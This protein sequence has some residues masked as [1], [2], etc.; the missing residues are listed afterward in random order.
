MRFRDC[1]TAHANLISYYYGIIF[2]LS[3]TFKKHKALF[4]PGNERVCTK[5][6]SFFLPLH[7]PK[8]I[9]FLF[10]SSLIWFKT[11]R[12]GFLFLYEKSIEYSLIYSGHIILFCFISH[13]QVELWT[14][15][16]Y[17]LYNAQRISYAPE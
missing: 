10:A 9:N 16:G 13:T 3:T 11:S 12:Y 14:F 7:I 4:N 17:I 5:K 1:V 2:H 6:K 8:I 15:S